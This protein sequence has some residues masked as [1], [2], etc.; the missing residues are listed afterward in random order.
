[1]SGINWLF[2]MQHLVGI[3]GHPRRIFQSSELHL[4]FIELSN[5]SIIVISIVP[6]IL[7]FVHSMFITTVIFSRL[8]L[9]S[10]LS[11]ASSYET[12]TSSVTLSL[13]IH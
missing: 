13:S 6:G 3:E 9:S 5:F 8:L 10:Q 12:S 7:L 1:M 4:V 2:G 11:T